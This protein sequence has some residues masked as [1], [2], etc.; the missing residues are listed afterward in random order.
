MT[1]DIRTLF[2]NASDKIVGNNEFMAH[3]RQLTK[4]RLTRWERA[5]LKIELPLCAIQFLI[6]ST[7]R[8]IH[9][10]NQARND[11]Y[12]AANTNE[13]FMSGDDF[14]N[15]AEQDIENS[16]FRNLTYKTWVLG[17]EA[18]HKSADQAGTRPFARRRLGM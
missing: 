11:W 5:L 4:E 18:F 3:Y 13:K 1:T 14:A 10:G 17:A 7:K 16:V 9:E 2:N 6:H 12:H 8:M 15:I